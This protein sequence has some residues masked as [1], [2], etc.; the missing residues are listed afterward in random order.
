MAHVAHYCRGAHTMLGE[1]ADP[2][3]VFPIFDCES[4]ELT[5]V[6]KKVNVTYWPG[7]LNAFHKHLNGILIAFNGNSTFQITSNWNLKIW[8]LPN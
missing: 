4:V 8:W 7:K 6:V 3:E 2:K 1:A 5:E